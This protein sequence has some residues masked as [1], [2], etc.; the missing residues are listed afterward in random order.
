MT[1]Q[2]RTDQFFTHQALETLA[3]SLDEGASSR[4]FFSLAD[5]LANDH[6]SVKKLQI[7]IEWG[8]PLV[9]GTNADEADNAIEV[10]SDIGPVNR[11]VA[12]D[13]RLWSYLAL[14]THR[15][16]MM[17][18][19]GWNTEEDFPGAVRRRWLMQKPTAR[20]LVR[21]GIAR[22]W[23]IPNLTFDEDLLHPLSHQTGDPFA[24]STWILQSENRRQ[25]LFEGLIGRTPS[26]RWA[27]MKALSNAPESIPARYVAQEL[28]KKINLEAGFRNLQAL[29]ESSLDSLVE[30]LLS[31]VVEGH[32]REKH[33][34]D[35]F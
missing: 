5:Q 28:A 4:E 31:E 25:Y 27:A 19:W 9:C 2:L 14:V 33:S 15:K 10:F 11:V 12:S 13:P 26:I 18:R 7:P 24:Y 6:A 32:R 1:D 3:L 17:Q 21:H 8:E 22:L 30:D 29:S 35:H 20:L 16:Y 23:W 34:N